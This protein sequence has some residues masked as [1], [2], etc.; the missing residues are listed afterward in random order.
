MRKLEW[1]AVVVLGGVMGAIGLSVPR[2]GQNAVARP[3]PADIT[4][5]A[6]TFAVEAREEQTAPLP[7]AQALTRQ[8]VEDAFAQGSREGF[9]KG[10]EAGYED[11]RQKGYAEGHEAGLTDGRAQG[12][13][14]GY[15]QGAVQGYAHGHR[16]GVDEGFAQGLAA[17][18]D[19]DGR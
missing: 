14:E 10:R 12:V 18:R 11:G 8:A 6:S 7:P 3:A 5:D 9:Q 15:Q 1:G 13:L 17:R 2:G 4:D 19:D 16:V